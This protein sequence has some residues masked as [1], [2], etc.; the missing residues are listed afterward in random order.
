MSESHQAGSVIPASVDP[1][2]DEIRAI[3]R[4]I[5][6]RFGNDVDR[7]I[8]HLREVERQ[9]PDRVVAPAKSSTT[10]AG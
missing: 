5:S 4:K 8:E 10:T 6:D 3:R 9:H 1:L 2:I 7:L